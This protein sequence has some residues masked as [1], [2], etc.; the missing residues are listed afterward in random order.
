MRAGWLGLGVVGLILTMGEATRAETVTFS[1]QIVRV[2]QEHCQTCHRPGG[3]APFALTS[4]GNA[5]PWREQI[6]E[7]TQTRKMPPWK[8]VPGYGEFTGARRLSESEVTLI[9]RWVEAG[10]PEGDPRDL[11]APKEFPDRWTLGQPDLTLTLE[12]PFR[13]AGGSGDV[14][15]CFTIPTKFEQD[16]Y[17]SAVEFIPD[18]RKIVHHLLTFLDT[19]GRSIELDQAEPGLGYTCFG[20]PGFVSAGGFGGW[21]PGASPHVMPERVGMLLPAGAHLVVQIHYH[22]GL[23]TEV[24]RTEVGIHFAKGP[25][26][27]R[28]RILPIWN[29]HFL[30]PA[31]AVRHEVHA[32]FTVPRMWNL[33]ALSISPHMHL[34]GREFRARVVY[35]DGTHRPLIY[36]DDWDFNW[37]GAYW[38]KTPIPVPGGT[39]VEVEC[40]YDNSP[41]NPRNPNSPPKDVR[42]GNGTADEMCIGF[43]RITVNDESLNYNPGK[44][45]LP[46]S[47]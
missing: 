35:P 5:Y 30:I 32:H 34:V 39:R 29:R 6:R 19:T 1:K 14:Y 15:R 11:P 27:K 43:L 38:Y 8:P 4:Y 17:V 9:G 3:G 18:N 44:F 16:R 10:A 42:W 7:A 24:D 31:D 46:R 20:S 33:H 41:K 26:E 40:V 23:N 25:I 37:Q 28:L 2:F 12:A 13:V 45:L 21:V 47:R 36:I 22:R